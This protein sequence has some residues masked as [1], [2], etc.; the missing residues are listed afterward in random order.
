MT[1]TVDV[2]ISWEILLKLKI[3][4]QCIQYQIINLNLPKH[5]QQS[6]LFILIERH[7]SGFIIDFL[8]IF[9]IVAFDMLFKNLKG[10]TNN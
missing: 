9:G 2:I 1:G 3:N 7:D 4:I 10:L 5:I 6:L 8:I